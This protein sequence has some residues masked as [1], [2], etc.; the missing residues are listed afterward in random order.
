V[1][2]P[3]CRLCRAFFELFD[4]AFLRRQLAVLLS[5]RERAQP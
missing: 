2:L 4:R 5:A 1:T 3:I